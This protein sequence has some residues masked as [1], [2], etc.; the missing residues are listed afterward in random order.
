MSRTNLTIREEK[1]TEATFPHPYIKGKIDP[2]VNTTL[3]RG[4]VTK[5]ERGPKGFPKDY[6]VR[7][8]DEEEQEYE[9]QGQEAY[10]ATNR[11]IHRV[12][13]HSKVLF[14]ANEE[15]KA[16]LRILYG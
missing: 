4:F 16:V 1:W 15:T 12:Q 11:Q 14:F 7:I 2:I 5:I 13:K 10:D 9:F 6:V 8:E 3:K